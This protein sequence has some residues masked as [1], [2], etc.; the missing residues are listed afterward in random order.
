MEINRIVESLFVILMI[1]LVFIIAISIQ[2]CTPVKPLHYFKANATVTCD[3]PY[4]IFFINATYYEYE[5]TCWGENLTVNG[6]F[7][8][9]YDNVTIRKV[10]P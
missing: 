5:Y 7:R 10:C 4:K 2:G 1:I 3:C 8:S 9:Y 6:R